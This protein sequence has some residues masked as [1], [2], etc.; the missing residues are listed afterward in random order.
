MPDIRIG[1]A[2]IHIT[3][4]QIEA[5]IISNFQFRKHK[6]GQ[7]YR[8]CNPFD[9]DQK[10]KFNINI[11]KGVCHDWRPGHQ[12]FDGSIIRFVQ[13]HKNI[14]FYEAVREICGQRLD[15]RSI[16]KPKKA[17]E[18]PEEPREPSSKLPDAAKTFRADGDSTVRTI[19]LN[20]LA[21]R[22]VTLEMAKRHDLH[23]D[24]QMVYF[25]YR[26]YDIPVYWQGRSI[27]GKTF[28]FPEND[29]SG[30]G[31]SQYLFGFDFVEPDDVL[32][33]AESNFNAISL[34]DG[35]TASGGAGMS[36]NQGKKVRA[37]NPSKVILAPDND[38]EGVMSIMENAKL[39]GLY[40][41]VPCYFVLPPKEYKDWN[42]MHTKLGDQSAVRK[43]ATEH[44]QPI[45][46]STMTPL[47]MGFSQ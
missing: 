29:K 22:G 3:S 23:Y 31:K 19:A 46:A 40:S 14:S 15:L 43:W 9:G 44:A 13:R 12:N 39:I 5:W 41:P 35:A 27:L 32:L 16:L 20:Y 18:V 24:V 10:Y 33:I 45:D 28:L 8:I 42:E 30:S 37:L 26:E 2:I 17:E 38:Y 11:I 21:T 36:R 7:E 34:G 6:N 25:P 1:D 4:E 47:I